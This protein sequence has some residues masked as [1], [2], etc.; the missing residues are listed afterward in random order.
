MREFEVKTALSQAHYNA[1]L[2]VL[3]ANGMTQAGYIRHLIL[4]D[5]YQS[6]DLVEQMAAIS[7]RAKN[8][9]KPR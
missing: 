5:I 6:Q 2:E 4:R 1:M 3:E 8:G 9:R 7:E